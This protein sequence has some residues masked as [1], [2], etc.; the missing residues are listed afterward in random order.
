MGSLPRCMVASSPAAWSTGAKAAVSVSAAMGRSAAQQQ[1]P[2]ASAAAGVV[3]ASNSQQARTYVCFDLD[4]MLAF[5]LRARRFVCTASSIPPA[6]VNSGTVASSPCVENVSV[7]VLF[8][9]PCPWKR[10]VFLWGWKL[11][12]RAVESRGGR[13]SAL[14]ELDRPAHER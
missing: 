3:A 5:C 8:V 12:N 11:G 7:G 14:R 1:L 4:V 13:G 9:C 2:A 10:S 6:C